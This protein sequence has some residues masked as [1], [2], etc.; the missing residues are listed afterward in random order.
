M[1]ISYAKESVSSHDYSFVKIAN[2]RSTA[3]GRIAC[4][5]PDRL[6]DEEMSGLLADQFGAPLRKH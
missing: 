3:D 4:G 6:A 1:D 2:S 5:A